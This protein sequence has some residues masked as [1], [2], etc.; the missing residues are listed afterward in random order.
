MRSHDR[1]V[2]LDFK[3]ASGIDGECQE[4]ASSGGVPARPFQA[5]PLCTGWAP[6]QMRKAGRGEADLLARSLRAIHGRA[7]PELRPRAEAPM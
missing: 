6:S 2:L 1:K 5:P 4:W 7:G 3:A